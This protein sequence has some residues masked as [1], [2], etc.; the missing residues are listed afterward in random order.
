MHYQI[1][2]LRG[3]AAVSPT[4]LQAALK[5]AV[6]AGLSVTFPESTP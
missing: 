2:P 4:R 5:P 1:D 6:T 3:D